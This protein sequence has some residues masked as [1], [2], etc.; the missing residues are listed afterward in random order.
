MV[1]VTVFFPRRFCSLRQNAGCVTQAGFASAPGVWR[2][3]YPRLG[4]CR[5]GR[6]LPVAG[7]RVKKCSGVQ[8]G[9]VAPYSQLG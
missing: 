2:A 7:F 5:A 6:D 4:Q 3:P 8:D 9:S 1:P